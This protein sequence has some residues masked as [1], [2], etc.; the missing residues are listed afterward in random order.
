MEEIIV[1]LAAIATLA[2]IVLPMTRG[3][4]VQRNDPGR[5][6]EAEARKRA[7]LHAIIDLETEREAGKLSEEDFDMLRGSA[8]AEALSA[9]AEVDLVANTE[10]DDD[11]LERE[12]AEMRERLTCPSC[13]ALRAPGERCTGCDT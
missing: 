10:L 3:A 7:A 2:Y 6:E 12:I 1:A 4:R 9:L 11:E 5:L 13:G 8:E